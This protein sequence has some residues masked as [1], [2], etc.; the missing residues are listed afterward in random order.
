MFGVGFLFHN[1]PFIRIHEYL[2]QVP[3]HAAQPLFP[4]GFTWVWVLR[5]IGP[6]VA[7]RPLRLQGT[8]PVGV[9]SDQRPRIFGS[10]LPRSVRTLSRRTSCAVRGRFGDSF[11]WEMGAGVWC[12]SGFWRFCF[13]MSDLGFRNHLAGRVPEGARVVFI[14]SAESP[15][16]PMPGCRAGARMARG[17]R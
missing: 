8:V 13:M 17:P 1:V 2:S 4:E 16:R 7:N 3:C 6:Q 5:E 10:L 14:F 9:A 11:A 15:H 12:G